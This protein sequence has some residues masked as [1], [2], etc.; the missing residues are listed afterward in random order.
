MNGTEV[1]FPWSW[2]PHPEVWALVAVLLAGYFWALRALGARHVEPVEFAATRRQ[3]TWFVLGC[4]AILGSADWPMHELSENY[5]YS[6]HMIQHMILTFAAAP[7]LMLG[8]PPWLWRLLLS[9]PRVLSTVRAITRPLIAL[10]VFNAVL[11]F[12]HWPL[13]VT[14][15][16]RTEGVHFSLHLL[17]FSSALVMWTPVLSPLLELPRLSYPGRMLYLFLQSLVPTIPASFLT[18]GSQPLYH[19]YEGFPRLWGISAHT[20]QLVAGLIMKI[21]GGFILWGV[22]A[23]LWFRWWSLEHTEGVDVL[24]FGDVDRALNR[25]QVAKS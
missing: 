2:H 7:L 10:A 6:A 1:S 21:V 24:A 8:T 15:S 20:D 5:L 19:V 16:V 3:K 18:F 25:A 4:A 23:V 11:V 22:I 12:T 17:L 14:S 9:S 13:I